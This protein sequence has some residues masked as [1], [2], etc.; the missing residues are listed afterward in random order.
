MTT[1]VEL[2]PYPAGWYCLT[3]SR[4]LPRGAV[5]AVTF[6]GHEYVVFRTQSGEVAAMDAYCPHLGAHMGHGGCVRGEQLECPFHGFRFDTKGQCV[7]TA[8]GTEAPARASVEPLLVREQ[9][10]LVLAWHHPEGL[11]PT[12]EIPDLD[13]DGWRPALFRSMNLKSHPQETT[14]NSVDLGHLSV[15]HGYAN[16]ENTRPIET[17]GAYLTLDYAITR[18]NPWKVGPQQ[19]R[20]E[21]RVHVHG[22]GV[23][24]VDINVITFGFRF[25]LYILP[26]P[27]RDGRITL[28]AG[29]EMKEIADLATLHPLARLAPSRLLHEIV[30]RSALSGIANDVGQD[31]AI[32]ENKVY[33]D[34]PVLAR[35]DGPIGRYRKWCRQFYPAQAQQ[36]T[37]A[38]AVSKSA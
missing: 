3:P 21:F 13:H 26:T 19:V 24:I 17:S 23:S 4:D 10:G 33:V 32:W 14:E 28:R 1:A 12:F 38:P 5:K 35:G 7:A 16:V 37:T 22:L 2:Y 34:P 29:L 8:Y 25:R 36:A 27:E 6:A 9:H 18:H 11:A 30:Q 31:F 20:T 15:V